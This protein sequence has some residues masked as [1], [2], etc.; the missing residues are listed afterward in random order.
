MDPNTQLRRVGAAIAGFVH[1]IVDVAAL[2]S[3]REA[4]TPDAG[5]GFQRGGSEIFSTRGGLRMRVAF[6]A[7][8]SLRAGIQCLV[9][10]GFRI[11]V[12]VGDAVGSGERCKS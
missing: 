4:G 7:G 11:S 12:V 8:E 10:L 5:V 1:A 6:V 9:D 2:P 3:G